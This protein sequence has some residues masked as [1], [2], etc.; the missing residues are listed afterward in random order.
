M[1]SL[2]Y[3]PTRPKPHGHLHTTLNMTLLRVKIVKL[4]NKDCIVKI[5]VLSLLFNCH[6]PVQ[7]SYIKK[8]CPDYIS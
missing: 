1:H 3:D 4:L 2:W 5:T 6:S 7:C 8:T